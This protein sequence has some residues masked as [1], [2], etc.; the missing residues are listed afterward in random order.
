MNK[1]DVASLKTGIPVDDCNQGLSL[2]E[3]LDDAERYR[4]LRS[5]YAQGKQTYFAEYCSGLEVEIDKT[6]DAEMGKNGG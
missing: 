3:L 5:Q 2:M 4:W 1:F 6:I